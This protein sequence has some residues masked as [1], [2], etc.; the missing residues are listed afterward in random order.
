MR[1]DKPL[2]MRSSAC[3]HFHGIVAERKTHMVACDIL[4]LLTSGLEDID[5][6]SELR[7][8]Y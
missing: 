5:L 1:T 6:E 2:R 3:L 4:M 8:E 7:M